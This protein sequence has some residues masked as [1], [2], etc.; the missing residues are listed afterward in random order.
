MW[1]APPPL[2]VSQR[3]H[4][5]LAVPLSSLLF[6]QHTLVPSP[7][8]VLL[9]HGRLVAFE[10]VPFCCHGLCPHHT[11]FEDTRISLTLFAAK[12]WIKETGL[13]R[14]CYCWLSTFLKSLLWARNNAKHLISEGITSFHWF[15]DAFFKIGMYL[16]LAPYWSARHQSP[17]HCCQ[18]LCMCTLSI[19]A[20][21]LLKYA[22]L[23]SHMFNECTVWDVFKKVVLWFVLLCT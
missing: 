1:E 7:G 13:L 23:M 5:V 3:L 20:S 22:L 21:F 18:R 14:V 9:T 19:L 4:A 2:L 11:R 12:H 15:W 8:P 10:V 16:K 17:H 6:K